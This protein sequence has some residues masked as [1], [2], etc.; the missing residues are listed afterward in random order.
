[1]VYL[2]QIAKV[3]STMLGW[4]D[5][6]ILT[7]MLRLN[8]GSSGQSA[9]GYT[10]D[11]PRHDPDGKFT[12]RYGTAYGMEWIA[13]AMKACGVRQWEDVKGRTIICLRDGDERNGKIVGLK[14]LPTEEGEEFLFADLS[15]EHFPQEATA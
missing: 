4:E 2:E 12:G 14:P 7:C 13:R 1:M 10:L 11:E 5:H 8:Y 15:A 6:G 3:E 9:G